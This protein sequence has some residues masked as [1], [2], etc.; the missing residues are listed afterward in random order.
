MTPAK[1]AASG[2]SSG[3]VGILGLGAYVP[4]RVMANAEWSQYVDTTDEWI[5]ER[6]G[7]E[8]RRVAAPEQSTVDLALPAARLALEDAG[9]GPRDVDEIIVATD[10]PEVFI[11]DTAAFVQQRLGARE[12]PA[13]DLAGSGC[14]G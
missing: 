3:A 9:I 7:I 8:R 12:V 14:A 4:E 11:P 1:G 6:T 10:T 2:A 5:R 13:Y